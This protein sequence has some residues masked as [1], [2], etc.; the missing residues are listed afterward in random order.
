[1][2]LSQVD[3]AN[4][5]LGRICTRSIA[6]L[7]FDPSDEVPLEAEQ[8]LRWWDQVIDEILRDH[9]WNCATARADI[10][11]SG[12]AATW[13]YDYQYLLPASPYCLRVLGMEETDAEWVVEGRYLLTDETDVKIKY[14][15][16]TTDYTEW[17]PLLIEAVYTKL[18]AK[19]AYPLTQDAALGNTL[20]GELRAII[21]PRARGVDAQEGSVT[22]VQ[23]STW[24]NSRL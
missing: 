16:R 4:L 6:T 3:I 17:E 23:T 5:A 11:G 13:G 22:V 18:A 24:L 7:T 19:L 12:S 15:K 2:S 21:L 20:L 9:P 10:S 1:M 8:V 14:I